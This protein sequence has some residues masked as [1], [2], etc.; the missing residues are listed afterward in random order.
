MEN[1]F[2]ITRRKYENLWKFFYVLF[3]GTWFIGLALIIAN[4]A[5]S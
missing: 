2:L 4:G 5:T 3:Y 1:K